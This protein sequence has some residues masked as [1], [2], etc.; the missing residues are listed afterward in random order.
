[1]EQPNFEKMTNSQLIEYHLE[2][3][4]NS[5]ALSIY[6]QRLN[7]DPNTVWVQ[8]QHSQ[9]E[10]NKIIQSLEKSQK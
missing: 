5:E 9:Q 6:V 2:H 1:M 4:I 3:G 8:P 10:L 7:N